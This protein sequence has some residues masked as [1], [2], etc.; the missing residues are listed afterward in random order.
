ML[1]ERADLAVA[2]RKA[3][4][5]RELA[6]KLG[7]MGHVSSIERYVAEPPDGPFRDGTLGEFDWDRFVLI[8]VIGYVTPFAGRH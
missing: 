1:V 6:A 7:E 8:R 5:R 3:Q 2:G 4:I